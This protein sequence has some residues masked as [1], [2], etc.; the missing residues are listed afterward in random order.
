MSITKR[1]FIIVCCI[2][3]AILLTLNGTTYILF[4]YA[5]TQLLITSQ[6]ALIEANVQLSNGF[7][8][9]VDQLVYQYTSDQQLGLLL[10]K[11]IGQDELED[12]NIRFSLNNR[13]S[14]QLNAQSILLNNDFV[15]E[16]YINP[17]LAVS[18][19]FS[20]SNTI[21]NVSRVFSGKQ[22]QDQ[23]WYKI[24][25][26]SRGGQ[27]IFLNDAQTHLCFACK[28][29]NS[30][31]TGPHQKKGLGVLLGKLPVERLPQLLSLFPVTENS[32]VVL[33]NQQGEQVF[34]S[35]NLKAAIG[36]EPLSISNTNSK[37]ISIQ[38]EQYLFSAKNLQW[39]VQLV[40]LTPY[41]DVTQQVWKMMY[42]YLF[43]SAVFLA[44]GILLSLL[45][46]AGISRPV[47]RFAKKLESI[48]DTRNLDWAKE[49]VEGPREI[50]QL[51]HS[52]E[53]LIYRINGLIEEL[54]IKENQRRE[55]ELKA[56][57]AQIN[58]HF[59]LNA[60]NAVNYMALEREQDDIAA[61]VDSIATLMRY[62]ITEPDCL[63]TMGTELENIQ[64]YISVY[65]L[66]FRQN[67][68]LQLMPGLPANQ[69][70]IPKFTLQ[71]L[72]ENSMRHGITRQDA[73][74]TIYIHSY[75]D[76]TFTYI[77]VTDTG[78]GADAQKLNAYLAYEDV[79]LK[80]THGFGIRN[81]NERLQLRFGETS[82][83]QY[84]NYDGQK[85]LARLTIPREI[86][87]HCCSGEK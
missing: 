3:S 79:D 56:L 61:T 57:Q 39:G 37:R 80:V 87:N 60:M 52:F 72:V 73:G 6:Q 24:S 34:C 63:V 48:Q 5:I 12:L 20:P 14:Y 28:L 25:Q 33:L 49:P 69:V 26:E 41:Q 43:C 77:D 9:T 7:T 54:T 40:F 2:I 21:P 76:D 45:L 46:S 23:H 42:P 29:Q 70:V 62:S 66:R 8:Q 50:Q 67:I 27:Y 22:V 44:V 71:P 58:P 83:L 53:Q 15:T 18:N 1:T 55:S 32:G 36:D 30:S 68:Q 85:L 84:F 47:V 81:V 64:E 17:D 13:L 86:S 65:M 19:L 35:P 10:S 74:I 51:N 38:G 75:Q 82:S 78:N 59:M 31:F 4:Q 16:L 11:K